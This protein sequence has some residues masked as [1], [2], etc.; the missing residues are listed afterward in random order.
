M[1]PS[2]QV[3][4]GF[5]GVSGD[6]ARK[7]DREPFSVVAP[8]LGEAFSALSKQG[9]KAFRY[10]ATG[11]ATIN[12]PRGFIG[13]EFAHI[14]LT[15]WAVSERISAAAAIRQ[16]NTVAPG[17]RWSVSPAPQDEDRKRGGFRRKQE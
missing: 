4:I 14:A 3:K 8:G 1:P 12:F 7:R 15:V 2:A 16:L 5:S 10:V 17:Y 13:E 9:L 6:L 11:I